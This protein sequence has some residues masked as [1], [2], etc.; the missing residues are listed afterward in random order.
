[1][2]RFFDEFSKQLARAAS[3]REVPDDVHYARSQAVTVDDRGL[4]FL[5]V[6]DANDAFCC[7]TT[8]SPV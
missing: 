5:C 4:R 6:N 8:E 1:M 3:R 2:E 7:C